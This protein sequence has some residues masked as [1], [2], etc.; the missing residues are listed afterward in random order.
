MPE[1][2]FFQ[3]GTLKMVFG[4][5]AKLLMLKIITIFIKIK[6]IYLHHQFD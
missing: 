3:Q 2:P 1:R 4:I 6:I 5:I